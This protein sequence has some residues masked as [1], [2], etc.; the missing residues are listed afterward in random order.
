MMKG[1]RCDPLER[2]ILSIERI[3]RW[4]IF[5]SR[6]KQL[7][8]LGGPGGRP[9]LAAARSPSNTKPSAGQVSSRDSGR[10]QFWLLRKGVVYQG[11]NEMVEGLMLRPCS[12]PCQKRAN[13]QPRRF[14]A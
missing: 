4:P 10:F 11:A 14:P 5:N 6:S 9:Q 7:A 12:T 3:L 1:R 13:T 8:G 2:Q